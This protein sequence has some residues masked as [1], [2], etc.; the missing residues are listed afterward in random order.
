MTMDGFVEQL[1]A[2]DAESKWNSEDVTASDGEV[3]V[4]RRYLESVLEL[5]C[6]HVPNVSH[7]YIAV[8]GIRCRFFT[9]IAA[10][11]R[12]VGD[13]ALCPTLPENADT[14]IA[15]HLKLNPEA[16]IIRIEKPASRPLFR[17]DP[18][19]RD[20]LIIRLVYYGEFFWVYLVGRP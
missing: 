2:I 3:R 5:L 9:P 18:Q 14:I 15:L 4:F 1:L 10:I 7:S 16:N 19:V 6:A 12:P 8:S 20:K 13:I 11:G 17:G